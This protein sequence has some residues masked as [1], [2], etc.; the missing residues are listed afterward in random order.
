MGLIRRPVSRIISIP[1]K[2][3]II[4]YTYVHSPRALTTPAIKFTFKI[5]H[6]YSIVDVE[7]NDATDFQMMQNCSGM[8]FQDEAIVTHS[9]C[10]GHEKAI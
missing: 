5:S 10:V 8:S 7:I 4:K 1:L 3:I 6:I 9:K 2:S